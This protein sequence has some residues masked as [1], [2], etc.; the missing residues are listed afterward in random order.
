MITN[1]PVILIHGI[2]DTSAKMEWL[3]EYLKTQGFHVHIHELIPNNASVS[4]HHL[5]KELKSYLEV[6]DIAE[7]DIVAFSMGGVVARLFIQE[8]EGGN[9]VRKCATIATPH[10]GTIM[11]S[12]SRT[13]GGKEMRKGSSLIKE[14]DCLSHSA[15]STKWLSIRTPLDLMIIPSSSSVISFGENRSFP[16]VAHPLMVRSRRVARCVADFLSN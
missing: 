2:W 8:Y 5:A 12:L 6:N 3:A 7:C 14:L 4:M 10:K 15:S 9:K 1:R 13:I 11:A 16:I